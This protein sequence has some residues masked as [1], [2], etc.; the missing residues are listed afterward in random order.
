[1]PIRWMA[2]ECIPSSSTSNKSDVW[3]F[4]VVV[5]EILAYAPTPYVDG[6]SADEQ[7]A[8][9][10]LMRVQSWTRISSPSSALVSACPA[11][12]RALP[13]SSRP[14]SL[15]G[16]RIPISVLYADGRVIHAD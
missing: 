2:P 12:A 15:A 3:A 8:L 7:H 4:G 16:P 11:P 9:P 1:M 5:W 6:W 13:L 10:P 14:W